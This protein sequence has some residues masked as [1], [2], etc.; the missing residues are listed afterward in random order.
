MSIFI[1]VYK[2]W[3]EELERIL[4]RKL[5]VYD[6]S[7]LVNP[8]RNDKVYKYYTGLMRSS[9]RNQLKYSQTI[10][11]LVHTKPRPNHL[12]IDIL[13]N[14]LL[15]FLLNHSA[16]LGSRAL[17]I[18]LWSSVLSLRQ[19]PALNLTLGMSLTVA[20][21]KK[22]KLKFNF[23]S[24]MPTE[25]YFAFLASNHIL[26][27]QDRGGL[28]SVIE[29]TK[30]GTVIAM[31][32]GSYNE[33]LYSGYSDLPFIKATNYLELFDK[34]IIKLSSNSFKSLIEDQSRNATLFFSEQ[35]S[36]TAS[37]LSEVYNQH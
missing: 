14:G 36:K 34:S 27:A 7:I 13:K 16:A 23:I 2:P 26:I 3:G 32:S 25:T 20:K 8:F 28:G 21:F 10:R 37:K 5:E 29:A 12:T 19:L 4:N 6:V 17:E 35:F 24:P 31:T 1:C 15:P 9:I 30:N 11:I 22:I 33:G 18:N